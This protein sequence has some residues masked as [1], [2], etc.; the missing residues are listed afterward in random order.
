[1]AD[2]KKQHAEASAEVDEQVSIPSLTEDSNELGVIRINNSVVAGIVRLA[3][4]D[5]P[6]VVNVG[7]GGVVEGIT[8]FFSK[9]ESER[10]VTVAEAKGGGYEIEVRVT[11][12]FGIDL[13][14]TGVAIQEAVREQILSMTGN[15]ASR[16]DVVIDDIKMDAPD[17]DDAPL[18]A[19]SES[20]NEA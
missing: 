9:K 12:K 2:K 5:V 8:E 6:G 3:T 19:L 13:A 10:G 20:A 11:L 15:P 16:I 7:G 14:K 18:P 4:K 17:K 1:M